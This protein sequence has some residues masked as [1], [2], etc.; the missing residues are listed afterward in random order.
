MARAFFFIV[1]SPQA[2]FIA[3]IVPEFIPLKARGIRIFFPSLCPKKRT[4]AIL[5]SYLP[6]SPGHRE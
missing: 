6:A 1:F 5:F 4:S 2:I 3:N